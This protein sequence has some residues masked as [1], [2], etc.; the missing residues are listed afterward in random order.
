MNAN[1][2][3][4]SRSFLRR[5]SRTR[6]SQ[7]PQ[8]ES[9]PQYVE[10]RAAMLTP[11]C[12]DNLCAE[13]PLLRLQFSAIKAPGFPNFP[14]QLELLAH[15]LEDTADGAFGPVCAAVR[16]ETAL[17]LRYVAKEA[18]IIPDS[19]PEIGYADDSLIVRTVLERH[20]SVFRE[21]CRFRKQP[22]SRSLL[23][24]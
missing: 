18:D 17:A 22:W 11:E 12:L 1:L 4:F 15:F 14:R 10:R 24:A 21:Y 6:R 5:V 2:E 9:I 3:S 20:A 19:I 16:N 7:L 13:L 23:A 8:I